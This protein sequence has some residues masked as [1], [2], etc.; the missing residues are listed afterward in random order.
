M[1]I[2]RIVISLGLAFLAVAGASSIRAQCAAPG[3]VALALPAGSLRCD[4]PTPADLTDW[5]GRLAGPAA[6]RWVL[7]PEAEWVATPLGAHRS[8]RIL[9]DGLPV[10]DAVLRLHRNAAGR[11]NAVTL[12]RF[13]LEAAPLATRMARDT[14]DASIEHPHTRA[15]R[16]ARGQALALATRALGEPIPAGAPS[17][18]EAWRL[19]DGVLTP[20]TCVIVP[21]DG[22]RRD[23]R[24]V[25]DACN[26][27]ILES[28]DL[29]CH[30][31]GEGLVFL[32]NPVTVSGRRELREGDDVDPYRDSVTLNDLDGEGMLRGRWALIENPRGE[33]VRPDLRFEFSTR[34]SHF[35]E[36][37]AYHHITETQRYLRTL[38]YEHMNAGP[39]RAQVH[40]SPDDESW[41][42]PATHTIGFGDGG[43]DDAE[44]AD[45]VIHEYGHALFHAVVGD[46]AGAD[47]RSLGE[48][49]A[50]YL[51]ASRTDDARIGDWDGG[52][53]AEGCLRDIGARYRYPTD[54]TGD[55]HTDGRIWSGLLWRIRARTGVR[56]TDRLALETLYRFTPGTTWAQAA[57]AL[58]GVATD[59]QA[60]GLG[61][62][63]LAATQAEMIDAGLLPNAGERQLAAREE[64]RFAIA[65]GFAFVPA[66]AEG[67][68]YAESL[69][70]CGDGTL[71][72][73]S[74]LASASSM[75][76][77]VAPLVPLAD[78]GHAWCDS[79]RIGWRACGEGL[80]VEQQFLSG[81]VVRREA[82]TRIFPGGRVEIEWGGA[83]DVRG[84]PCWCGYFPAGSGGAT[85]WIALRDEPQ[86]QLAPGE[87]V[88]LRFTDAA[89]DLRG[90]LWEI[91]PDAYGA[92]RASLRR[93]PTPQPRPR[94]ATLTLTPTATRNETT[95]ILPV[96]RPGSYR[97]EI[98]DA[99]GRRVALPL[100]RAFP[101]GL[102]AWTIT[103]RDGRGAPLPGGLYWVRVSGPG[104][105]RTG[106]LAIVH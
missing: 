98:F 77:L 19:A 38:G 43:V 7:Q 103:P 92:Y 61:E 76:P 64:A 51:A 59:L 49:F 82:T 95:L 52:A 93:G 34:D 24:L 63:L 10:L 29:L 48:G 26:G 45:V 70:V 85:R 87:G 5:L 88:A 100:Q 55:P 74:P 37:M 62:G 89:F 8:Y 32:P 25:L 31:L 33:S 47:L 6:N 105:C 71:R 18:L 20:I 78:G 13:L 56:S 57:R 23:E 12:P 97:L 101:D 15:P 94:P 60:A 73:P 83:G 35:E 21:V 40:A 79:L 4:D 3:T 1:R 106:R 90:A 66:G 9:H 58:R 102:H 96:E 27:A 30:A 53:L 46:A 84:F 50:D 69:L 54:L 67:F 75:T 68:V 81:G 17:T 80:A 14:P 42:S 16:I 11:V 39:Q 65:L 41:F 86:L 72:L 28:T 104:T 22:P 99:T 44:D 36:V 91:T 2:D